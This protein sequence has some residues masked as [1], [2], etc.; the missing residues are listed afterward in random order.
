MIYADFNSIFPKIAKQETRFVTVTENTYVPIGEYAFL[1]S[2]CM[3]KKCDC[4]RAL[5]NVIQMHPAHKELHAATIS[6]GWEKIG[7]YRAWSLGLSV[8]MLKEFK[9]PALDVSQKQSKYAAYF[10]D[11]FQKTLLK[12]EE[13]ITR[14]KKQY[15]Y[16]KMQQVKK[17]PKE[18]NRLIDYFGDCPCGSEKPFRMCCGKKKSRLSR[19]R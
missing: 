17:L 9:G 12:D 2:F 10:L 15:A 19:S 4:R 8:E 16:V 7:F 13:Y 6:Y 14:I 5:I 3:D 18:L 11:L 1:P